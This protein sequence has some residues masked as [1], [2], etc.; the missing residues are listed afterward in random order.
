MAEAAAAITADAVGAHVAWLADD[1]RL[2]RRTPG[3]GLAAS[4]AYIAGV[5][6][7]AGLRPGGD[8]GTFLQR[9]GCAGLTG[10]ARPA[11]VVAY[12]RGSDSRLASE[13]IVVTAHY[14][15]LG[16]RLPGVGGDTIYNGADDDASGTA[17]LLE[18][19]RAF[20][21][22]PRAPA[23]SVAFVAMGGEELGLVG[24][25]WFVEH[26]P[27]GMGDM[28]ANVNLDMVGRN[29]P[30]QLYSFGEVWSTVGAAARAVAQA[31]PELGFRLVALTNEDRG[32][33]RSD[34]FP[35]AYNGIPAVFL[36]TGTEG[37]YHQ[38]SD[39]AATI[40]NEKLSRVARFTLLL[41]YDLASRSERPKWNM[42]WSAAL[43]SF[44]PIRGIC[45]A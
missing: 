10:D 27:T 38:P 45:K 24:S 17:A 7:D 43:A 12:R 4:A 32:F 39:E 13:W 40:D 31:H 26:R 33:E 41:T 25:W 44:Q 36:N 2:G 15:G 8:G 14:D 6:R 11:N 23:R 5:F 28:A 29:A 18:V 22:L 1:E 19:A 20:T 21:R 37:E 30:A 34:Q 9:F 42:G 16:V 35:F 3:P